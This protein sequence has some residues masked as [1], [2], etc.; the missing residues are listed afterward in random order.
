MAVKKE[1]LEP[2]TKREID[3]EKNTEKQL[4]KNKFSIELEKR[5][6][7]EKQNAVNTRELI[8]DFKEFNIPKYIPPPKNTSGSCYI[9]TLCYNDFYAD[10][11][12]IFRD[13]RDNTLNKTKFGRLFVIRY[14]KFA[15]KLTEKLENLKVLNKAIKHILLNPLLII[16]KIFKLDKK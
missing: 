15:P 10:E 1:T 6:E 3:I 13:F 11:V 5:L 16:I 2:P 8:K 7:W 4:I 12:C 14:Y 9:A